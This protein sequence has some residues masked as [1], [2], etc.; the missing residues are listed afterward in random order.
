M[1]FASKVNIGKPP[2][3]TIM[4]FNDDNERQIK[5]NKDLINNHQRNAGMSPKPSQDSK[6]CV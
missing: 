5:Q 1:L 3:Q 2:S 4:D 6:N